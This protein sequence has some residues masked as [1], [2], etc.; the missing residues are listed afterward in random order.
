MRFFYCL[1]TWVITSQALLY[2][3]NTK[4]LG[5]EESKETWIYLCGLKED[6]TSQSTPNETAILNDIGQDLH[7]KIIAIDPP[8]RSKFF[9]NKL[10]WPHASKSELQQTFEYLS[11]IEKQE[12][13]S[14]YLGFSNGGFFLLA[15]A[16]NTSLGAPI[17]TIGAGG[18]IS[19]EAT[20][21]NQIILLIGKYDSHHYNSAKQFYSQSFNTP[22]VVDL[23]EYEGEHCIPKRLL[24]EVIKTTQASTNQKF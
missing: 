17:I 11:S 4:I 19:S 15:L 14:G 9:S 21:K 1:L 24:Y 16:Q 10:C 2:S 22:L 12:H 8:G 13:I 18:S 3:Y 20:V 6:P 23:I 5:D 7:I